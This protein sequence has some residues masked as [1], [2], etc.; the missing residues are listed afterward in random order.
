[1]PLNVLD[2]NETGVTVTLPEMQIT[3]ATSAQL[4][5]VRPG[6][7]AETIAIQLQP[8]A[9]VLIHNAP[10]IVTPPAPSQADGAQAQ[11]QGELADN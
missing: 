10:V 2:W 8:Q 6:S 7:N 1:M 11:P 5:I 4:E 3:S 9:A